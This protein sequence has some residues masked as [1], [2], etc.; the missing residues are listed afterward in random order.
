MTLKA[1]H[2]SAAS[3]LAETRNG[4]RRRMDDPKHLDA[5][6]EAEA[7]HSPFTRMHTEKVA[8]YTAELAK[9]MGHSD[10]EAQQFRDA[11]RLHDVGK[12]DVPLEILNFKGRFS[13]E[14]R[15]IMK[16]HTTRGTERLLAG[17]ASGPVTE[18]AAEMALYHHEA[19]DGTGYHGLRG[20][21]IPYSA[22]L[23]QVADVFEALTAHR[24]Y[25]EGMSPE[26]AM[27]L[28]S[29]ELEPGERGLC[30]DHFDPNMLEAFKTIAEKVYQ[31]GLT[32]IGDS[33]SVPEITDEAKASP[34]APKARA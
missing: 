6:V 10:F 29:R 16:A 34:E 12:M 33:R 24:P 13:D 2:D 9:A 20:R 19:Y 8:M 11:A 5:L 21:A 30:A 4:R 7:G 25:K 15:E 22:R 27:K 31:Q 1:E 28:M 23:C 3:K 14:Q 18:M 32:E 26:A 17:G